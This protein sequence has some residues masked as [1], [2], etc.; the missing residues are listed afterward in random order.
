MKLTIIGAGNIGGAIARGLAG[1]TSIKASD[2]TCTDPSPKRL[3]HIQSIN[4]SIRTT[5]DNCDAIKN[6]DI[7]LIAVKPWLVENVINE[8]KTNLN[9]EKQIIVS[10]AAGITFQQLET[11]LEKDTETKPVIF[12]LIPNTAIDVKCSMTFISAQNATQEQID[13]IL[14]TFNELGLTMLLEER[15]IGPG[16]AL[17]SSGIAFA[18]RYIRA[19]IEGG[20]E[21]G[22][23]PEQA[24]E[25]VLQTFKGAVEL[26]QTKGTH[27]EQEI[28]KVTTPGGI[29][30]KGLNAMEHAG[31]TSAVIKGLLAS[32]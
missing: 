24:T 18:F 7:I 15:L 17:G 13:L 29:T 5:S 22:F 6:A 20:I 25:I 3:E 26:L 11:F 32:K 14:K 27:P 21:L 30:I 28:D 2:I 1:G 12:R 23:P 9:F 8:I 10:I 16:T 19:A 31:F 4:P